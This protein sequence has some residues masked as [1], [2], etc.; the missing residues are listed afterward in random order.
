MLCDTGKEQTAAILTPYAREITL[1][2]L[3]QQMLVGDVHFHL[4]FAVKATHPYEKRL[5]RPISA[6]SAADWCNI[7]KN[8]GFDETSMKFGTQV[9]C[10]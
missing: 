8:C 1:V 2:F 6:Y 3:N 4:K 9:D 5:L 10:A 7:L